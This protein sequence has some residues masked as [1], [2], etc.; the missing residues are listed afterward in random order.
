MRFDAFPQKRFS[1]NP[2]SHA[3]VFLHGYGADGNDL[4]DLA[5]PFSGVLPD[6]VYLS[7]H[8]P[9]ETPYSGRQ[10]FSLEDRAPAAISAGARQ[11]AEYINALLDAMLKVY[12]LPPEKL[13]LIGFSQGCMSALQVGLRRR[14]APAA[15]IGFSGLLPELDDLQPATPE[16]VYPPVYLAHGGSDT[17]VA[18]SFSRK[19]REDLRHLGVSVDSFLAPDAG[20]GIA[21][22]MLR[23]ACKWLQKTVSF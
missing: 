17:V 6:A 19:A 3:V 15:V 16:N 12:E 13:V 8:A 14:P 11:A 1:D 5:D 20:H 2:V 21:P 4:I 18:P 7:P 9:D 23:G 10:W 22:T